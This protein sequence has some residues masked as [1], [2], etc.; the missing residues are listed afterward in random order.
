MKKTILSMLLAS[1]TLVAADAASVYKSGLMLPANGEVIYKKQCATCHGDSGE[2]IAFE[3]SVAITGMDAATLA[4]ELIDYRYGSIN[5][6][7]YGAQMKSVLADLSWDE[8]DAV[9]AYVNGLK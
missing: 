3:G 9:S 8:L 1:V 7:G 2:K 6:Y 4:K 5:K